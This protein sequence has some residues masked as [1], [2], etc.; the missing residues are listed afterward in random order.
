MMLL[1][2]LVVF[3]LSYERHSFMEAGVCG[4]CLRALLRESTVGA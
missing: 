2:D 1:W 4:S 3:G